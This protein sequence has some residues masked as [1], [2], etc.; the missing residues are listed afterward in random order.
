[1]FFY[2]T[3]AAT[4]VFPRMTQVIV[5]STMLG[6]LVVLGFITNIGGGTQK[7]YFTPRL[8]EFVGGLVI[9]ELWLRNKLSNQTLG[10]AAIF[11][12]LAAAQLGSWSARLVEVTWVPASILVV[13]GSLTCESQLKVPKV[14]LLGL[15]GDASYVIYLIHT[16]IVQILKVQRWLP[17]PV[18]IIVAVVICVAASLAALP[19][20]RIIVRYTR[21]RL[22]QGLVLA[23]TYV[24]IRG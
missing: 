1:M 15:I 3:F 24:S 6:C 21:V 9:A 14:I 20:E 10:I 5:L 23:S 11:A 2:A 19:I 7:I 12:G 13:A 16:P 17:I 22:S 4:L 8:M 18:Q